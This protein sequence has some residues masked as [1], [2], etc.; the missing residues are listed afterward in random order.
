[1]KL[2][3]VGIDPDY[4]ELAADH[5]SAELFDWYKLLHWYL[6]NTLIYKI[7]KDLINW[8]SL[9]NNIGAWSSIDRRFFK[10]VKPV[11]GFDLMSNYGPKNGS[12]RNASS[13]SRTVDW[14]GMANAID[15]VPW[16]RSGNGF[17]GRWLVRSRS[18]G[19]QSTRGRTGE[20]TGTGRLRLRSDNRNS[21]KTK[22]R[23][24]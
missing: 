21:S 15:R 14:R 8:N 11:L 18:R 3:L 16:T 12:A 19:S 9:E 17:S 4:V 7:H 5:V 6:I 2:V 13:M 22:Q 1:M 24:R 10:C 20:P 23:K